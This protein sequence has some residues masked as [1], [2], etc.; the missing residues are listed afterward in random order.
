[1]ST[2]PNDYIA[3]AAGNEPAAGEVVC[4]ECGEAFGQITNSH[5]RTRHGA[6]LDAY[7]DKH[8]DAPLTPDGGESGAR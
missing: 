3:A 7:T 5:L 2:E 4:R 1:M 6:T 8:P